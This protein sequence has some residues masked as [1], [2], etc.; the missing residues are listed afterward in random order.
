MDTGYRIRLAR[1]PKKAATTLEGTGTLH[2]M[3]RDRLGSVPPTRENEQG[4]SLTNPLRG[5]VGDGGGEDRSK[6]GQAVKGPVAAKKK[7]GPANAGRTRRERW[8]PFQSLG[9]SK[10]RTHRHCAG[11]QTFSSWERKTLASH[12]WPV[13]NGSW[14]R[15]GGI[16]AIVCP[17]PSLEGDRGDGGG[18]WNVL[19]GKRT[20]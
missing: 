1:R 2:V 5:G 4:G 19:T 7:A 14:D 6:G 15:G 9:G 17:V 20:K 11:K 12:P 16:Q 18:V 13:E 3:K 8:A 10:V